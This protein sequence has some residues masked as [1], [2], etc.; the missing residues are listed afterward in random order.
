MVYLS[1]FDGQLL[2]PAVGVAEITVC[3]LAV[4]VLGAYSAA[5]WRARS[6]AG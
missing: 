3:T 2:A 6:F 4:L 5:I 1:L